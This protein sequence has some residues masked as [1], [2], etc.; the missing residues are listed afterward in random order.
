MSPSNEAWEAPV[1][2]VPGTP[3]LPRYDPHDQDVL[4]AQQKTRD[5]SEVLASA[6][7]I[8]AREM[9][10]KRQSTLTAEGQ[11][12]GLG[13]SMCFQ[14]GLD[15]RT[16]EAEAAAGHLEVET[17]G[18]AAVPGHSVQATP[19]D[20]TDV[21]AAGVI[22]RVAVPWGPATAAEGGAAA[23]D[24]S[25]AAGA[26]AAEATTV[27]EQV[28]TPIR[29][30]APAA[31]AGSFSAV[32][33]GVQMEDLLAGLG[34]QLQQLQILCGDLDLLLQL[35]LVQPLCA[36]AVA[37]AGARLLLLPQP[38]PPIGPNTYEFSTEVDR[39]NRDGQVK[40][41]R[42]IMQQ[43]QQ[44]EEQS[45]VQGTVRRGRDNLT[46][47]EQS[48]DVKGGGEEHR[49]VAAASQPATEQLK[50]LAAAAC[51]AAGLV[52][53][54]LSQ[55]HEEHQQQRNWRFTAWIGTLFS[56]LLFWFTAAALRLATQ[57][58]VKRLQQARHHQQAG[59]NT[60]ADQQG[61][62]QQQE[63]QEPQLQNPKQPQQLLKTGAAAGQPFEIYQ[64]ISKMPRE[65]RVREV[66][67]EGWPVP[68]WEGRCGNDQR[69]LVFR[70]AELFYPQQQRQ[71]VSA[72][73]VAAALRAGAQQPEEQ[74]EQQQQQP[75]AQG[76]GAV[77]FP[78]PASGSGGLPVPKAQHGL[79]RESTYG[80]E[81]QQQDCAYLHPSE[82]PAL[83]QQVWQSAR[84]Q[85]AVEGML[86]SLSVLLSSDQGEHIP[87]SSSGGS[88]GSSSRQESAAA[89]RASSQAAPGASTAEVYQGSMG[90]LGPL[91]GVCLEPPLLLL[92][93]FPGCI[94]ATWLLQQQQ[95][96][97]QHPVT[98]T[99]S[100]VQPYSPYP[101]QP[102]FPAAYWPHV[103]RWL[104]KIAIALQVM[105]AS[106]PPVVHGGV[107]AGSVFLAYE[108]QV[109]TATT[110][111]AAAAASSSSSSTEASTLAPAAAAAAAPRLGIVTA[112]NSASSSAESDSAAADDEELPEE[113]SS[114]PVL[115]A[116]AVL[117]LFEPWRRA[118]SPCRV[119]ELG[120]SPPEL[121]K[122]K[123]S[124]EGAPAAG[125][126]PGQAA[127]GTTA[128]A[129]AGAAAG[130]VGGRG[131]TRVI[132]DIVSGG[133][134]GAG[135][136]GTATARLYTPAVDVY[137]FGMLMYQVASGWLP[138]SH[139]QQILQVAQ[140]QQDRP[141]CTSRA[142]T[143]A[144]SDF[145][146]SSSAGC[147]PGTYGLSYNQELSSGSRR[148]SM[149][150]VV[151]GRPQGP[152]KA[153]LLRQEARRLEALLRSKGTTFPAAGVDV[154]KVAPAVAGWLPEGY[155]ELMV[156]CCGDEPG[157]RP[158][159]REVRGRLQAMYDQYI[160]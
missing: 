105:H 94:L 60:H 133:A 103:L 84:T 140:Q 36:A 126:L 50:G 150:G 142:L 62:H 48:G 69:L 52:V 65:M 146:V 67:Q 97:Q 134:G 147:T 149:Q 58:A 33:G 137:G 10:A 100:K 3:P 128:A 17:A 77:S 121:I 56:I 54:R 96:Q 15:A 102:L 156:S 37:L 20:G 64:H 57:S 85:R 139:Q 154:R 124:P 34:T 83:R 157:G 1:T 49:E 90:G 19:Q 155:E 13:G 18:A 115:T 125:P 6:A 70:L 143:P 14:G 5:I 107:H 74:R 88:S 29:S 78:R 145:R 42:G 27:T 45:E 108:G 112:E 55:R 68:V 41:D 73:A 148:G 22:A 93:D 71:Q 118:A 44:Q 132:E 40:G 160:K 32:P 122:L 79:G 61:Q 131:R 151:A 59:G 129:A 24:A 30:T 113:T 72:A 138:I 86:K 26:A 75:L 123:S 159:M 104:S 109:E 114:A 141:H 98:P 47:G 92:P 43:Q 130:E 8:L 4:D 158:E 153:V 21:A 101:V 87:T 7:A 119:L 120:L 99:S 136:E 11:A 35:L 53:V 80:T 89:L 46:R 152:P 76:R 16:S 144:E 81:Q 28:E 38:A 66:P 25:E 95:Q 51:A 106:C 127:Q 12:R 110:S 91:V 82:H 31:S 116:G 9:A 63:V 117:L 23:G 111:A 39:Q 2:P 135:E